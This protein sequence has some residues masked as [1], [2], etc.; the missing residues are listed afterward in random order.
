[1]VV[2]SR[3]IKTIFA[4]NLET[5]LRDAVI[6]YSNR[7]YERGFVIKGSSASSC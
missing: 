6:D 5:Y 7:W 3:G 2:E 4:D 1:V